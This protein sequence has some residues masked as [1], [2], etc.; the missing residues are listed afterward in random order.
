MK[1]SSDKA[2][3]IDGSYKEGG[4]QIL[5]TA[6]ALSAITSKPVTVKNI[7]AGRSKPGLSAQH[8]VGIKAAAEMCDAEL[9]GAALGSTKITFKPGKI[10]GGA[11]RFDV[12]TAGAIT[13]VLQ[14]LVPMASY[15]DKPTELT[16]IGGTDVSWSPTI[17]FFQHAF[18]EYAQRMGVKISLAVPQRGFY[19]RG[20]GEV[21]VTIR[22]A[23][24]EPI[25]LTKQGKLEKIDLHAVAS[26]SL[27]AAAVC[28]RMVDGF[29]AA[30]PVKNVGARQDYVKTLSSGANLHAHAHYD[31]CTLSATVIGQRGVPA[32]SVG[33][34]CARA[35]GKEMASGATVDHRL[36][37]QLMIFM[38]L[39]K[40]NSAIKTSRISNH[41]NTNKYVIEQFLLVR[42]D[43]RGKTIK[44]QVKK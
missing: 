17:D 31:N 9:T 29:R 28:E 21:K 36:A 30:C 8:L 33:K 25:E 3:I 23:K 39:A 6:V 37:D 10:R 5:R 20:G 2:I 19:P 24:V 41:I 26:E 38:A 12:G 7:R 18:C 42:F 40:G 27:A 44:C 35:L 14:V 15:A 1:Q 4:G 16:I 11:Y 22:P 43:I 34:E 13:L 32:E